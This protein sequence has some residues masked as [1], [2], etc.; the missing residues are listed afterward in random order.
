MY[1]AIIVEP[2]KHKALSFVL[3]NFCKNLSNDWNFIIFH[4]NLNIDYITD[5]INGELSNHKHRISLLN[6]HVDNLTIQDYSNLFINNFEFYD[7]IPTEIFLVFQTDSMI[8]TQY[9]DLI[10]DFLE[11]DYV[12]APWRCNEVGNGGLSL[13]RKSKMLEIMKN[14]KN[15]H[16]PEDVYF[17]MSNVIKLHKPTF[18]KAKEFSIECILNEKSFG[19]HKPYAHMDNILLFK[20]YPDI[21]LLR[22]YN[23]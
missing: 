7:K 6:L 19:C 20:T 5:I 1:T 17:S 8:N 10:N 2:R 15:K 13:R 23:M 9:K 11:Y 4:G 18:E 22:N 16:L 3:N 12:G 14:D 21:E